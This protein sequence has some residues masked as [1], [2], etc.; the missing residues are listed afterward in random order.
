MK[1]L[2]V[3][4]VVD[5]A[6]PA[7]GFFHRWIEAFAKHTDSIEVICLRKGEYALPGNVR[8]HSLGK[9]AGTKSRIVYSWRFLSLVWGL[10]HDYD[11]VFV[12][13]NQ[14]YIL[15]AGWLWKL[16]GKRVGLWYVHGS[17]TP[18]LRFAI[19]C[20]DTVFTASE[21]SMRAPTPK[22][23]IVG[24]GIYI[25]EKPA[26]SP[27]TS[28][29][30]SLLTVGRI[31]PVKRIEFLIEVLGALQRRGIEAD[32]RIAG[33]GDAAYIAQ[34]ERYAEK[35]GVSDHVH[36]LG[37][38]AHEMVSALYDSTHIFVHASA[39][40]SIDK[41]PLE[42]LS[43]GVPVV[44][45]NAEYP[46]SECDSLIVA[47]SQVEAYAEAVHSLFESGLWKDTDAR[48]RASAWVREQ[49]GVEQLIS[50][51]MTW[52]EERSS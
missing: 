17:V 16:L 4:Q 21:L 22:K 19:R 38:I 49:Y 2:I 9:E 20:I 52:Y 42:A 23:R 32:L 31:S 44:T 35:E 1:L 37:P 24:H 14:E 13:M 41:A 40:G 34:L 50:R 7:L 10:R 28:I 12:H 47:P 3:T 33:H 30:L 25:N 29:P 36:L 46:A 5:R 48:M 51:L 15:L 11:A 26:Q 6:D 39:T 27:V 45:M 18:S 43:C 8:V